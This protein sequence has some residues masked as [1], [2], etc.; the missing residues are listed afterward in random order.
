M[1][2]QNLNGEDKSK[3]FILEVLKMCQKSKK[4]F[5]EPR[6][7]FGYASKPNCLGSD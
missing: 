6:L 1:R 2:S 3:I 4:N 7:D 5:C